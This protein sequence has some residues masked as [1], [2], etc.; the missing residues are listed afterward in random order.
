LTRKLP[1]GLANAETVKIRNQFAI[2]ALTFSEDW[3]PIMGRIGHWRSENSC[4]VLTAILTRMLRIFYDF[5]TR[6][7]IAFD[8]VFVSAGTSRGESRNGG[9]DFRHCLPLGVGILH[10]RFRSILPGDRTPKG[11]PEKTF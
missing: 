11:R 1:Q 10:L 8:D 7:G 5:L 9:G 6:G 2:R 4:L 3:I